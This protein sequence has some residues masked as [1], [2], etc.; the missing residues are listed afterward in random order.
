MASSLVKM[1]KDLF[2]VFNQRVKEDSFNRTSKPVV[3]VPFASSL[4][5]THMNPV[6]R[7]IA[8]PLESFAIHKSL[9]KD[10]RMVVNFV[11][12]PWEDSGHSPQEVRGQ[13]G[14]LDP[15]KNEEA[16]I[17]GNKMD[18]SIS[19]IGLPSDEMI[20]RGHL[21]G[22]SSPAEASQR[23]PLMEG[24]ILEVFSHGLT[25]T[26]V[27]VGLDESLVERFPLGT[28]Y[29]LEIDG[30][31][32]L[33]SSP[34]GLPGVKWNLDRPLSAGS[35]PVLYRRQFHQPRLLKTQEEFT[36]GHGLKHAVSLSPIPEATEF[37]GNE[38][39]ASTPMLFNN[40]L[41]K[42]NIIASYLSAPDDKRYLHGP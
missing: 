36:T 8:G 39:P 7:L 2:K 4:G 27:V 31:Q 38:G 15:G 41:D 26:Q 37:F 32:L 28:A 14:N 13:M 10:D 22:C 6:G 33:Q 29:H 25:V 17:L 9:Q 12:V 34:E 16:S 40:G 19:V 24:H 5:E 30:P 1:R 21:P 20:P 42:G 35:P 23:P 11:P 18:A 3:D